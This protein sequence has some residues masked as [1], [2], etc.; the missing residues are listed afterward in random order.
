MPSYAEAAVA[1]EAEAVG[2]EEV[3]ACGATL[4]TSYAAASGIDQLFTS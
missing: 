1:Y 4:I 3:A 2:V